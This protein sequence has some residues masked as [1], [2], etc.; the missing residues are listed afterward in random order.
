M[1]R[2]WRLP[3]VFVVASIGFAVVSACGGT[4]SGNLEEESV[5]ADQLLDDV[6]LG[7]VRPVTV[8]ESK[9][10]RYVTATGT[11]VGD[12]KMVVDQL[13]RAFSENG[14][15]ILAQSDVDVTDGPAT[16]GDVLI[17]EKDG[18]IARAAVF[19]QIGTR[20]PLAGSRWVQLAVSRPN[21]ALAWTKP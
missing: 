19:D 11:R 21:D 10:V 18:L 9:S 4:G 8:T 15:T 1:S 12:Q 3:L 13:T 6:E 5:A 7:V 20:V 2:A 14:W 17:A 16:E